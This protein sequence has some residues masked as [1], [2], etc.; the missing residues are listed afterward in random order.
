MVVGLGEIGLPI[1]KLISKKIPTASYDINPKL[2]DK[3]NNKKYE[4]LDLIKK[5]N[6]N[7]S[8]KKIRNIKKSK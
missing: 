2:I 7:Y 4:K 8:K 3:K 1:Y 6:N 5:I